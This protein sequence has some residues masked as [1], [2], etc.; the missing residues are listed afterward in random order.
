MI[1]QEDVPYTKEEVAAMVKTIEQLRK[2]N[3]YFFKQGYEIARR[4]TELWMIRRGTTNKDLSDH[5]EALG[6]DYEKYHDKWLKEI[7]YES[8]RINQ[9][10]G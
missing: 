4:S 8:K 2:E 10:I 9:E 6:E 1:V 5:E 7:Q 3:E